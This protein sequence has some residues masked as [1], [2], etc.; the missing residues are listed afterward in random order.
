MTLKR[1]EAGR[2]VWRDVVKDGLA[3]KSSVD[4]DT[5]PLGVYRLRPSSTVKVI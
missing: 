5:L 2:L 4:I 1:R 3:V